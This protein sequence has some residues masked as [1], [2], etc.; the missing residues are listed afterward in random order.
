MKPRVWLVGM[1]ALGVAAALLYPDSYQQD[2]G[3]HFLGARWAWTHP[4]LFVGVWSR[5]LFTFVYSFPAQFGFLA[6]KLF[7]VAVCLATGWQTWKLARDLGFDR[8][9]LAIP[10][11]FLQPSYFL[12][13]A[14]TMTEPI[15]A[16][17]FVVALRL[18]L[19]GKVTGGML[20]ASLMILARPE[21]FFLGVLWAVWVV[22][23]RRD[24][25]QGWKRIPSTALLATGSAVWWLAAMAISGDPLY[26][27]HHWPPDWIPGGGPYGSGKIWS[28]VGKLPEVV[29][30]FLLPP[31]IAGMTAC[32]W[33][34]RHGALTQPFLVVLAVHSVLWS[35][36][37]FG[38][39]GYP[40]YLVC[41]APAMA[42]ATLE[43][44]NLIA[45]HVRSW[46]RAAVAGGAIVIA[47][48]AAWS[49]VYFDAWIFS[50]DARAV[51][52]MHRWFQEH[53]QP[54]RRLVW[55]QA[56]MCILFD[57]DP[58]NRPKWGGKDQNLHIVRD[59]PEGTLVFW[60]AETGPGWYG[61]TPEDF[62][63]AGFRKLRSKSYRLP[64]LIL[65]DVWRGPG[66]PRDQKM[67]L[68]IR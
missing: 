40:R 5:P 65:G 17:V 16:L 33:G 29:G 37:G 45:H 15:F 46:P 52:E 42:L 53:P 50:R 35:F 58:W 23:D 27:L 18:H 32:L 55:S 19:G 63:R 31:F 61:L 44:W 20:V 4:E 26:I 62:E 54:F 24:P 1:A 57:D 43:G 36:G 30:P 8:P 56:Y 22:L 3:H 12:L 38:S 67:H 48:S 59:L 34:R 21:G 64:G 41:V 68:L 14:D 10:L 60:D 51:A 47:A 6:A 7:T 2:G 9:A 39:A 13:C 49:A 28:Y 66:G 11:L 25:G